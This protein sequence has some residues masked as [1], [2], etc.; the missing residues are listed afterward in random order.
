MSRR[1]EQGPRRRRRLERLRLVWRFG[2][3]LLARRGAKL[4]YVLASIVWL[5]FHRVVLNSLL[6]NY[7]LFDFCLTEGKV[8]G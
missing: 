2:M 7:A 8:G 5:D 4:W 3:L 6:L 1:V